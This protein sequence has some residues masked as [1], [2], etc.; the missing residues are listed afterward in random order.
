L[1]QLER[2]KKIRDGV[3]LRNWES[4]GEE[5]W[6]ESAVPAFIGPPVVQIVEKADQAKLSRIEKPTMILKVYLRAPDGKIFEEF[7][8]ALRF[9]RR[10]YPSTVKK[11]GPKGMNAM[12]TKTEFSNWLDSRIVELCDLDAW[13]KKLRREKSQVRMPGDSDFGHWLFSNYAN[14]RKKVIEAR[15][16]LNRAIAQIPTLWTQVESGSVPANSD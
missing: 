9:A 4:V 1:V 11:P 15:R 10:S 3:S 8:K 7:K 14:P 13:R 16:T 2:C 5:G 12:L 6:T